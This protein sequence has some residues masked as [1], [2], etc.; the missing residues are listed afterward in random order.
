MRFAKLRDWSHLAAALL[1]LVLVSFICF[2]QQRYQEATAY[3][4][5]FL[6][7]VSCCSA[8]SGR[9]R[10][11]GLAV[12]A[13]YGLFL[14]IQL[15]SILVSSTPLSPFTLGN[16]SEASS[17][18]LGNI[19]KVAGVAALVFVLTC[20]SRLTMGRPAL[21]L[22]FPLFPVLH[23][24]EFYETYSPFSLIAKEKFVLWK[25]N[26]SQRKIISSLKHDSLYQNSD[27]ENYIPR[28]HYNVVTIFTEGMSL[29]V[30]SPEVT[31]NLW[32]MMGKS[33]VF[34]GYFNHT[35]ATFRGLRGQ[36]A[37]F[38]QLMDQAQDTPEK[39]LSSIPD[40]LKQQGYKSYFQLSCDTLNALSKMMATMRFDRIYGMDDMPDAERKHWSVV[41]DLT[42]GDSYKLLWKNLQDLHKAGSPF[43]YG[44]Y[45]VGTHVGLDSP[46][47]KYGDGTNPYLNKFYNMDYQFGEFLKKFKESSVS[48]NTL[49]IFTV[50]HATF[51]ETDFRKTFG[52]H[53]VYFVDQVPLIIYKKGMDKEQDLEAYGKNSLDLAPTI[54]DV[55]GIQHAE[56]IF[57]GCSLFDKTCHSDF[58]HIS[59]TG[60]QYYA[61]HGHE[62][63]E[64]HLQGDLK[65][66]ML[67][68][69]TFGG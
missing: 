18:G 47:L 9:F 62:V 30:M 19:L 31:P 60:M 41:T 12:Q 43:Y 64:G 28:K 25:N 68:I 7:V 21:L 10:P 67:N 34:K 50:D 48:D 16:L 54:M 53:S 69:Q 2:S 51:P 1:I 38:Y 20:L 44:M 24:T 55:L 58:D 56:N 29:G 5:E 40:L 61:T 36:N 17:I 4:A 39:H 45:T 52:T 37:S 3:S 65:N 33:I 35:A 66:L 14:G 57:L 27:I 42:D 23:S 15:A 46:E 11:V 63:E 6:L 49:L 32:A 26:F 13:V 59:A 8:A 22:V